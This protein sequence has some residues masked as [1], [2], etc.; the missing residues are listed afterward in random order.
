MTPCILVAGTW[1][2]KDAELGYMRDV[3][4]T[5]GGRVLT[6]D[7]SV[8]GEPSTPT[9]MSKHQ[10]AEAA[11]SSIAAAIAAEDENAAMQVMASGA[12]LLAAQLHAEGRIPVSYTH[13][14]LP[15]SDL[16]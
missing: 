6:M 1:D 15:T 11:G 5:Q 14:T 4:V 13:L 16:V 7:V 8:L 12:A 2:T 9:D 10:V 3:I